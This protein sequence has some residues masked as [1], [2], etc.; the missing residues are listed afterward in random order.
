MP[1]APGFCASVIYPRGLRPAVEKALKRGRTNTALTTIEDE[2]KARAG[3]RPTWRWLAVASRTPSVALRNSM[4]TAELTRQVGCNS[5]KWSE[6]RDAHD[7]NQRCRGGGYRECL[8]KERLGPAGRQGWLGH[9]RAQWT[10]RK[11]G[12]RAPDRSALRWF[13]PVPPSLRFPRQSV[14]LALSLARVSQR[15]LRHSERRSHSPPPEA[16]SRFGTRVVWAAE[17]D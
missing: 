8:D 3:L 2:K 4:A 12:P 16:P 9:R 14:S 15:S 17:L 5:G 10:Q 1:S 6:H 7:V 11:R 13:P